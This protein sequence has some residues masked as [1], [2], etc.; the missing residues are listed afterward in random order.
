MPTRQKF[1]IEI[2]D[3]RGIVEVRYTG[4]IN[5]DDRAQAVEAC[6]RIVEKTGYFKVLVDL[7]GAELAM[8]GPHEEAGF[9][10]LLSRNPALARSRTAYLARPD[11]SI[12]WFIETLAQARHYEC[13]HFANREEAYVW[14]SGTGES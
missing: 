6:S 14:L 10:D 5:L 4:R 12:N 11:Q 1:S 7:S 9:A 13:K 2:D 3:E 8:Q